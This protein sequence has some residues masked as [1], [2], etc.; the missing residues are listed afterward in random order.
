[1]VI[2]LPK[3]LRAGGDTTSN[4]PKPETAVK[5]VSTLTQPSVLRTET[6]PR[7]TEVQVRLYLNLVH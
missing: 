5:V 6:T 1:M 4:Q 7:L 3:Y 2:G